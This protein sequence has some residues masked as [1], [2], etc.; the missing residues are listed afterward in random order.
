LLQEYGEL[1]KRYGG[2]HLWA[3]GYFAVTTGNV[4]DEVIKEYIASHDETPNGED[5]SFSVDDEE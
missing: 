3:R 1:S 4:N 5:D 2:R